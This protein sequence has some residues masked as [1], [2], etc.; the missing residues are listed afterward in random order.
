M[1]V[2][3][4][5]KKCFFVVSLKNANNQ[6]IW[7]HSLSANKKGVYVRFN[8][9]LQGKEGRKALCPQ[10]CY[11][12]TK[13]M[14]PDNKYGITVTFSSLDLPP[15]DMFSN[16]YAD[17]N[18]PLMTNERRRHPI[19]RPRSVFLKCNSKPFASLI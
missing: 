1:T 16:F 17:F 15:K 13:R 19:R 6:I 10:Y 7:N 11:P 5:L 14:N 18:L 8:T 4:I 9:L 3:M 12:V 2:L